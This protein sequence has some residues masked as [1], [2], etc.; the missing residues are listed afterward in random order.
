MTLTINSDII[1][2]EINGNL[3]ADQPNSGTWIATAI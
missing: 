3:F 1:I 2:A